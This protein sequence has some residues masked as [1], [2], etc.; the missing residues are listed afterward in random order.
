V[1]DPRSLARDVV[2]VFEPLREL[3]DE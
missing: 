2:V 1:K 3:L